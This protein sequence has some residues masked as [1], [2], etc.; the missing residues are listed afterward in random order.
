MTKKRKSEIAK[1]YTA[2]VVNTYG[3]DHLTI[4]EAI[5]SSDE[6]EWILAQRRICQM[7]NKINNNKSLTHECNVLYNIL[8][9]MKRTKSRI[10]ITNQYYRV[11]WTPVVESQSLDIFEL[12]WTLEA[13]QQLW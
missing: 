5:H 3:I 7:I 10:V 6:S 12:Y 1:A 4:G 13:V 11:V 2:G 8:N 9:P